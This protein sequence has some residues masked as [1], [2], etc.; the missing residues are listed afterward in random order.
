MCFVL[1]GNKRTQAQQAYQSQYPQYQQQQQK[2]PRE[3]PPRFLR[4]MQQRQQPGSSAQT[5]TD[6]NT[7]PSK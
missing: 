6:E 3:V 2:Y 4:Q 5:D 1:Q 7:K